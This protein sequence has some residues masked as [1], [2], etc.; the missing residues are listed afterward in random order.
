M[1][2]EGTGPV[3]TQVGTDARLLDLWLHDHSPQTQRAHEA[4]ADTFLALVG[5]PLR[6]MTFGDL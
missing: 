5:K 3:A 2:Y 6:A 1:H 4:G